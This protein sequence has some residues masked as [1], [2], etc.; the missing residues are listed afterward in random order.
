VNADFVNV[1]G[2]CDR[3]E[4]CTEAEKR[5]LLYDFVNLA[6]NL[7]STLDGAPTVFSHITVRTQSPTFRVEIGE[8]DIF[9]IPSGTVDKAAVAD[10]F[11]VLLPPLPAGNH[12]LHFQGAFCAPDTH[13]P[14]FR[15][16]VTYNLTVAPHG[17]H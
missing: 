3:A 7:T 17:H 14:F 5:Q 13:E 10:G 6:C 15:V 11:W 9:A 2:D 1:P 8:D 12:V 16:E 4:G